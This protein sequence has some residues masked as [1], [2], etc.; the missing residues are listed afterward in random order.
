MYLS[1][2][3]EALNAAIPSLPAKDKDFASSL[4][5]QFKTKGTLSEKQAYW[6]E[7]LAASVGAKLTHAPA[8]TYAPGAWEA[9]QA[10]VP[11]GAKKPAVVLLAN[12]TTALKISR[13]FPSTPYLKVAF[14]PISE[15]GK[16]KMA[17]NHWSYCGAVREDDSFNPHGISGGALATT[18]GALEAFGEDMIEALKVTGQAF[19]IC[20][21]CGRT[22]THPTSVAFGIGP[23]CSAYLGL[24]AEYA[25]CGAKLKKEAH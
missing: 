25:A 9:F 16:P 5:L 14:Q 8:K 22:L 12:P 17:F 20:A 3:V 19:G 6:V 11:P 13:R 18:I 24:A 15:G 21:N 10:A 23:T 2:Q 4:V 7:K 1:D